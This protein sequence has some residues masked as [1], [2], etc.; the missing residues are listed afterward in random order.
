M[1]AALV[2]KCC[3]CSCSVVTVK[4]VGGQA[5]YKVS[6]SYMGSSL[7]FHS[8]VS[9]ATHSSRQRPKQ[10]TGIGIAPI[11]LALERRFHEGQ[12]RLQRY[13]R[14]IIWVELPRNVSAKGLGHFILVG[15]CRSL[16]LAEDNNGLNL[17]L[18]FCSTFGRRRFEVK[19]PYPLISNRSKSPQTLPLL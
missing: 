3:C 10:S 4:A 16:A 6:T 5:K 18:W 15:T 13:R 2:V 14:R 19:S 12:P 9:S 11:V 8:S 7:S 1:A 17:D